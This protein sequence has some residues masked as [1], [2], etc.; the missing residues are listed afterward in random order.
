MLFLSIAF[1]VIL[2]PSASPRDH[3]FQTC[4][5]STMARFLCNRMG[6]VLHVDGTSEVFNSQN[7]FPPP[8]SRNC[9]NQSLRVSCRCYRQQR[10]TSQVSSSA[11]LESASLKQ[12]SVPVSLSTCVR[13]CPLMHQAPHIHPSHPYIPRIPC[14][15]LLH[16]ARNGSPHGLLVRLRCCRGRL[17][18][19]HRV[20]DPTRGYGDFELE[21]VVYY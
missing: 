17:W 20:R 4:L 13:T 1:D 14:S 11:G 9:P 7:G 18:R 16:Q 12:D 3:P 19:T 6:I 10:S 2:D 21:A 15:V 5:S 8:Y